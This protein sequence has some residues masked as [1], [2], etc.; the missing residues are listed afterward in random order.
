MPLSVAH[1]VDAEARSQEQGTDNIGACFF[2]TSFWLRIL[3]CS[4]KGTSSTRMQGAGLTSTGVRR[5]RE[6]E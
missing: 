2:V 3:P 5:R 1:R 4:H 6:H